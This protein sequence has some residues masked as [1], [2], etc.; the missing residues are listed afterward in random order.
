MTLEEEIKVLDHGFVRYVMSMGTEEDIIRAARQSTQKDFLG[1]ED[2]YEDD[3]GAVNQTRKFIKGDQHLLE[4]LY[5]N[6]HTSP[7]EMLE[8]CIQVKAPIMVLRQWHRHRTQSYNEWSGRY[9]QLMDEFY[10]PEPRLQDTKNK[11]GSIILEATGAKFGEYDWKHEVGYEQKQVY[12]NYENALKLGIA[13]E[14]ARINMPVSVYTIMWAKANLNNWFHFLKLRMD[15]H[16]QLEI[17]LYAN[18]VA[19]IIKSLWPRTYALFEEYS[20]YSVSL[21]RSEV[22]ALAAAGPPDNVGDEVYSIYKRFTK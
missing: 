18:A 15:P 20:L 21:S 19:E 12:Y 5:K 16:A 13:K 1:W 3:L 9:S 10:V 4:Y 2:R 22:Q 7:F 14:V 11:Q 6:R 17:R 8:L